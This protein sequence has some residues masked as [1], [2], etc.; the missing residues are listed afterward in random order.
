MI[1][2]NETLKN[3][4]Q[5]VIIPPVKN[6]LQ[7]AIKVISEFPTLVPP[8]SVCG[9]NISKYDTLFGYK[10]DLVIYMTTYEDPNSGAVAAARYCN[11]VL[12]RNRYVI[13]LLRIISNQFLLDL[14]SE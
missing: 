5:E 14:F 12:P 11:R 3:Y 1:V 9:F 6:L 10:A 4:V 13:F 8:A 2:G 7:S